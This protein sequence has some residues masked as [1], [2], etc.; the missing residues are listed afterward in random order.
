M[1]KEVPA[2]NLVASCSCHPT[3]VWRES[4]FKAWSQQCWLS[5]HLL[6][7]TT[8][9]ETHK[10][11]HEIRHQDSRERVRILKFKSFP[12]C[13][14]LTSCYST[15]RFIFCCQISLGM[16]GLQAARVVSDS[17]WNSSLHRVAGAAG[18]EVHADLSCRNILVSQLAEDTLFCSLQNKENDDSVCFDKPLQAKIGVFVC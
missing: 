4:L 11:T 18:S 15:V 1:S 7:R 13:P 9:K 5:I 16:K 6:G 3:F 8:R 12:N 17:I 2:A 10:K 14:S